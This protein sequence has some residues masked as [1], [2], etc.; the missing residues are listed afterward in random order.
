VE[1]DSIMYYALTTKDGIITGVHESEMPITGK[2]FD[3]NPEL[4]GQEV[5][6]F[7]SGEYREGHSL[8][9][10]TDGKLRPLLD[11]IS[12]G[13]A[14]I[15]EGFEL[16][17]GELV[18]TDVPVEEAPPKLI[19]RIRALETELAALKP[20]VAILEARKI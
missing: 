8:A 13:L 17:D 11:R 15:P 4:T 12:E 2:T 14:N 9:E 16:I 19:D 6:P 18:K 3:K 10:Y 7:T 1:E 5:L 20:K